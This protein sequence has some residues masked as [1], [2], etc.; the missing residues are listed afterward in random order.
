MTFA[1]KQMSVGSDDG[2]ADD[3]DDD[4]AANAGNAGNALWLWL[5]LGQSWAGGVAYHSTA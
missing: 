3:D 1:L 5:R 2:D 4:K